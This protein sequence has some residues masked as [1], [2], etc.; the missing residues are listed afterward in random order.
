V[1]HLW[2]SGSRNGGRS[3]TRAR[4]AF[5]L[6]RVNGLDALARVKAE[7]F[8]MMDFIPNKILLPRRHV[9]GEDGDER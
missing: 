6:R 8:A 9:G 2:I 4:D 7:G 5:A 3:Q 1:D